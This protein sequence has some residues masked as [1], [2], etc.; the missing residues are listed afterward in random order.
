MAHAREVTAEVIVKSYFECALR[1]VVL[2][3]LFRSRR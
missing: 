2:G 1:V 3:A